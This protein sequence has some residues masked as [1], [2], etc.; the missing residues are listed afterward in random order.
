MWGKFLLSQGLD[1]ITIHGRTAKE[2]S[3]VPAHWEEIAKV[4]KLRRD[5]TIIIGNGDVASRE[6]ALAKAKQYGVDGVMIGRGV[7]KN[8]WIFNEQQATSH[9]QQE[10]ITLLKYHVDLF[11][12]IYSEE[13]RLVMLRKYFKIYIQGFPGAVDLRVRLMKSETYQQIT[14]CIEKFF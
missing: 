3:K 4:V 1:A 12:E 6:D 11:R 13:R 8:P 2:L 10:K 9:K 5:N 14:D 7:F